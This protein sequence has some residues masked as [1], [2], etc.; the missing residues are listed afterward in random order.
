MSKKNG[1]KYR[2][3][4]CKYVKWEKK[5]GPCVHTGNLSGLLSGGGGL[6]FTPECK[7]CY[8]AIRYG[9]QIK[10]KGEKWPRLIIKRYKDDDTEFRRTS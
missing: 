4:I 2:C 7:P 9:G 8:D 6:T 5:D 3:T 1:Y 10:V